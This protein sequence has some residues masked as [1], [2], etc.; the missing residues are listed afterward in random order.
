MAARE[1]SRCLFRATPGASVPLHY[2]LLVSV[3]LAVAAAAAFSIASKVR[4][5]RR[6]AELKVSGGRKAL[7]MNLFGRS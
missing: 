6:Y 2:A 1:G 3:V 4:A 5:R 7:A